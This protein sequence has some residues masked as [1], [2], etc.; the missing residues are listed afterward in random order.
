MI[1]LLH[2]I[3]CPI[4]GYEVFEITVNLGYTDQQVLEGWMDGENRAIQNFPNW[5][6][7]ATLFGWDMAQSPIPL[8]MDAA[9]KVFPIVVSAYLTGYD[10]INDALRDYMAVS[11]PFLKAR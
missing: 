11:R 4:P 5:V 3:A 8:T 9:R 7:A 6:E 10:V 1:D 2:T